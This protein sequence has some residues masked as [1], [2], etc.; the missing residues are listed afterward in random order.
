MGLVMG[1]VAKSAAS[2]SADSEAAREAVARLSGS[3]VSAAA[4][5]GVAFV[6]AAAMLAFAAAGQIAAARGEEAAGY[7]DHLLV[8]PVARWRWLAGRVVV[9]AA[10]VL[11]AGLVAGVA[12]WAGAATQGAGVGIGQLVEAGFNVAPPALFVLGIELPVVRPV[13][14][15]GCAG[16]LCAGHVVAARPTHLSRRAEQSVVARHV[17]AGPH[18]ASP[19]R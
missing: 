13:A 16:G 3:S 9:A 8:R 10:L 18:H 6:I 2:A 5:L 14:A 12:A 4:F 19:C 1:S 15:A 11:V 7:L 17:G